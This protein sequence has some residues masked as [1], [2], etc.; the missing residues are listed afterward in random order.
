[1]LLL[2]PVRVLAR[3]K[4]HKS[5]H[6]CWFVVT[7]TAICVLKSLAGIVVAWVSWVFSVV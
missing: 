7:I 6:S 4:G 1:M 5:S 3:R 2:L